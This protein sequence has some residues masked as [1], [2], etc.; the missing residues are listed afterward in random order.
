MTTAAS[1]AMRPSRSAL[2]PGLSA[3]PQAGATPDVASGSSRS[4]TQQPVPSKQRQYRKFMFRTNK[5]KVNIQEYC[6]GE[7]TLVPSK[8]IQYHTKKLKE[9]C[10]NIFGKN[11]FMQQQKVNLLHLK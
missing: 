3:Q 6:L 8:K 4:Q 2:C 5:L 1:D 11:I 10:K 7:T 9:K